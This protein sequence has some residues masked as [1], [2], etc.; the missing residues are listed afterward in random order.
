[1]PSSSRGGVG[2]ARGN[3]TLIINAKNRNTVLASLKTAAATGNKNLNSSISDN[4]DDD[5]AAGRRDTVSQLSPLKGGGKRKKSMKPSTAGSSL[6][7]A[8]GLAGGSLESDDSDGGGGRATRIGSKQFIAQEIGSSRKV[9]RLP[10]VQQDG[11]K[12]TR[13]KDSVK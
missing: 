8:G 11:V 9:T 1:M 6:G 12:M 13:R 4:S 3:S 2:K 5:N 7:G 10:P